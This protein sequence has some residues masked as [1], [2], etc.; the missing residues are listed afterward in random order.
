[1]KTNNTLSARLFDVLDTYRHETMKEYDI[2][3]FAINVAIETAPE[4]VISTLLDII[5][6]LEN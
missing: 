4:N 5:E 3:E 6:D 1:M 2:S